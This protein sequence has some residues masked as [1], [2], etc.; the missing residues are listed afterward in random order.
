MK[1]EVDTHTHT[2]LSGHA[3]STLME[4]AAA[5]AEV[6]LLGMVMSDHGP[7]IHAAPPDFNIGTY[8]YL[9]RH[10]SGVKIYRGIEAN[11]IDFEGSI[12]I[13]EKYLKRVEYAIAGMHEFVIRSGGRIK[14]TQ[15]L[16]GA[17]ENKYIDIIAHPDNPSYDIDYEAVVKKAAEH[18]KLL[19]VNDHSFEY[20]AGSTQ[21]AAVFLALCKK[22]SVRVA[23]SSD[24]HSAF[25]V[26]K[27]DA[28]IVVLEENDFPSELVI[29]LTM[30][31]FDAYLD[32]RAKRIEDN[33]V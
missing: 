7:S 28:A 2:V 14:D 8:D 21:N 18:G 11:I 26:G 13:R 30:K 31:R 9:P 20:R 33:R 17:L 25:G 15:A 1:L 23:V 24:A 5:A 6:G 3:H 27:H 32:E 12:D 10:I 19:E 16:L 4:N 29:N 22:H